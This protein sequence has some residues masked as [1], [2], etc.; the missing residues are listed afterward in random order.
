V[1]E[2]VI[3]LAE[4]WCKTRLKIRNICNCH[5][6]NQLN[7]LRSSNFIVV[8]WEKSQPARAKEQI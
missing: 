7:S 6:S 1:L 5:F 2:S 8:C 4:Y 3:E